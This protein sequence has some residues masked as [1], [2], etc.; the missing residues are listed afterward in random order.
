MH[1]RSVIAALFALS[2]AACSQ[3]PLAPSTSH[4]QPQQLQPLQ[5]TVTVR[6]LA[7]GTQ[8]PLAG[9][10]V[11]CYGE[12]CSS[13]ESHTDEFGTAHMDV[14][15]NTGFTL[16]AAMDGYTPF[17]ASADTGVSASSNELWTFYLLKH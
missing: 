8:Q 6:V 5:P 14:F 17:Y 13:R 11:N 9:A 10:R 12:G 7:Q 4:E 16:S 1:K 3:S 2:T 15:A